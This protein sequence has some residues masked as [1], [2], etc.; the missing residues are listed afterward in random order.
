MGIPKNLVL[1]NDFDYEKLVN[2]EPQILSVY[3]EHEYFSINDPKNDKIY[4]S[5][6]NE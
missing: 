2:Y 1:N 3:P 5:L 4:E 6:D